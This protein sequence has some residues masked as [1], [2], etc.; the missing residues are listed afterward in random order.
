MTKQEFLFELA[1]GISALPEDVADEHLSFYSEMIDDR[2]EEGFSEEEAVKEIGEPK[3]I[4]KQILKDIPLTKLVKQKIKPQRKLSAL[5]ILL[6]VLGFPLWFSLL[7]AAMAIVFSLYI[8]LWSVI[9]SLWAVEVSLFACG[10]GGIASGVVFAFTGNIFTA[11][12]MLGASFVCAGVAILCFFA[13]KYATKGILLLTKKIG[14]C[15]KGLF[16]K[17]GVV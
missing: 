2:I 15:I 14:L 1:M 3:E 11:V 17:K 16:I 10:V 12:A 9:I 13:C 5:E 8:T 7:M 6:I 4:V